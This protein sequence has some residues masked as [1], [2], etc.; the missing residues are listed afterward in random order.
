MNPDGNAGSSSC[1]SINPKSTTAVAVLGSTGSVG[2][3]TLDVVARHPD[4]YRVQALS[5]HSKVDELF[6]QCKR[7]RP[8]M[9]VIGT[10]ESADRLQ[11]LCKESG[12][13]IQ[14]F[15]G[16]DALDTIASHK[17][18]DTVVAAIVG[19]AGLMSTLAAAQ[20]GKRILLANKEALVMS[21]QLLMNAARD[22]NALIMPVDSEHNAIFQSLPSTSEGV[23]TAGIVKILLTASGGPLRHCTVEELSVVSPQ[24]ALKH[25]NWSMGPKISIDSA[26]LM[27][28]GLEVIEACHLFDVSIDSIEV[29]VHPESLIHS[30]VSYRDG[31]V[32]AQMG[33]P[34]MRTPI[35]H[36]LAWPERIDAGVG[37]LD[38][39]KIPGL[40]F[41]A[42]D[43]H[44]FPLLGL[45][46]DAMREGG[47]APAILNAANEVAVQ[48]F[49]SGDVAFLQ[50]A[51][52]VEQTLSTSKISP[53]SDLSTII[54][55]DQAAREI[56]HS[57]ISTSAA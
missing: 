31:S 52:V 18:V 49:L 9:A 13:N 55:A 41:E 29:V 32:I 37:S 48:G 57:L 33:L 44:R 54:E 14:V 43:I 16:E 39:L 22:A 20:A 2:K 26:T 10:E 1:T 27:N 50:L 53:A 4:R 11:V 3:S 5:A 56:A 28:K 30:M 45:A 12:L 19:A 36:A 46:Y 34:D 38:F 40:H 42:P 21:G 23:N 15:F 47:T 8:Q 7:F 17:D 51:D 35:A 6:E 24:Q 25:P